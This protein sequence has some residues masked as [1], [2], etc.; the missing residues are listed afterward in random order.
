M[1][2]ATTIKIYQETKQELDFFREYKNESYDD[3]LKKLVYIAKKAKTEPELSKKTVKAIEEARDR[4]KKGH[5][6]SLEDVKKRLGF[7][8]QNKVRQ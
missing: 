7:N 6:T 5:Y 1:M 3:V 2:E 8:V 4:M